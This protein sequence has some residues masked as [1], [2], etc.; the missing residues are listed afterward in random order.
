MVTAFATAVPPSTLPSGSTILVSVGVPLVIA[1]L[2]AALVAIGAVF[3][4]GALAAPPKRRAALR[5]MTHA[6]G[7][8][9]ARHAA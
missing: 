9:P 1:V 5:E 2:V 4:Q 3:V 7:P 8:A 6:H